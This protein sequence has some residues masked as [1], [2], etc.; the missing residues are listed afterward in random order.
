MT[1]REFL[2][3]VILISSLMAALSLI[4]LA[5]PLQRRAVR[6]RVPF[7]LTMSALIFLLNWAMVSATALIELH[8]PPLPLPMWLQMVVTVVVLDLGT[9]LAHVT[10][11]KAPF[12]WRFHR[13]HHS[14]RFV[15]ATT[16]YRTHPTEGLW[17]Y[18]WIFIP[19]L[20][21]GLPAL[22]IV[23]YRLM[24]ALNGI[25]EH[26]NVRC[27]QPLDRV[28]SWIWVTPNMHKVHHS[29]DPAETDSNYGNILSL[30]DRLFRTFTPTER[31]RT[32]TYGLDRG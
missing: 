8:R 31:G 26:A 9:Y 11:H 12:L 14:D 4:E 25:F 28:L 17:R 6:G 22:G 29:N 23:V 21:L 13:L 20:L 32:V 3:Y 7:N 30:F 1:P 24:S 2:T 19:A 15:D 27:W 18:L 16:T 10:M 5:W